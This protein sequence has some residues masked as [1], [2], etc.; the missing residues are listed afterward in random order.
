MIQTKYDSNC[1]GRGRCHGAVNVLQLLII[2]LLSV[3]DAANIISPSYINY[4]T[5]MNIITIFRITGYS[6]TVLNF[7]LIVFWQLSRVFLYLASLFVVC[8]IFELMFTIILYIIMKYFTVINDRW[9]HFNENYL[10]RKIYFVF[11]FTFR[12]QECKLH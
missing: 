4:L 5:S 3:F 10:I 9:W 12:Y 7:F 1:A 11:T 8:F 2:I 6:Q